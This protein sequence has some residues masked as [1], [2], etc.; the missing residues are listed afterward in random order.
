VTGRAPARRPSP[1]RPAGEKAMASPLG[2]ASPEGLARRRLVVRHE[3]PRRGR[4]GIDVAR[5]SS[6]RDRTSC[7]GSGRR[8]PG[9]PSRAGRPAS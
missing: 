9:C 8:R 4:R 6:I 1:E 2:R 5:R 3:L 7:R